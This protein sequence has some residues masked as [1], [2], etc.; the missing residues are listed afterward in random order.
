MINSSRREFLQK[1]AL[2]AAA[3]YAGDLSAAGKNKLR[4][5]FSTLGCPDWTFNQI[6][7]F[8]AQHGYQGLELRGIQRQLDLTKCKE[9]NTPENRQETLKLIKQKKLRIVNL[10]ASANLHF[11]EGPER[12]KNLEGARQ[13]IDLAQQLNCP[14]IRVFPDAFPKG[15]DKNTTINLI[16]K[17]LSDL[18]NYAKDKNV[19]VLM[20]THGGVVKTE[21]IEEIMRLASD[22]NVGLVWDVANMWLVTKEPPVEVYR[23]LRKYIRHTHIKDAEI[24]EGKHRY[25]LIGQG[26]VPIF[27]AIDSLYKGGYKG[28]Y[29]FEWEKLW[30]PEIEEPEVALAHYSKVMTGKF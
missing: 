18:G 9:F 24:V 4:L 15:Q 16:A 7:D 3:F 8:A 20:E 1:S 28:Y 14:Y 2:L 10:G 30:H 23:K 19:V 27:Q 11:A 5:S 29:S 25:T 12:E 6:V 22:T 13:F 17:G 26:D 21:D